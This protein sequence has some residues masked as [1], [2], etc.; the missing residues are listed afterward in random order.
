M[1]IEINKLNDKFGFVGEWMPY[2]YGKCGIYQK[3][4]DYRMGIL[5]KDRAECYY[6]NV[7]VLPIDG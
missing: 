3:T 6:T 2:I 1:Q 5:D 7:I 4:C